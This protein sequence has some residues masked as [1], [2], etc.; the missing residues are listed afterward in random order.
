VQPDVDEFE[1]K[2]KKKTPKKLKVSPRLALSMEILFLVPIIPP[3]VVSHPWAT[4]MT[5]SLV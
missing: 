2:R 5:S 3:P 4:S 1:V